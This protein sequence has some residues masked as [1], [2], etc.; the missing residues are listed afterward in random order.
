MRRLLLNYLLPLL[1]PF[2]AYGAWVMLVRWRTRRAGETGG[3]EW[4]DA[5]WTWLFIA[6]LG[7]M[8]IG[9]AVFGHLGRSPPD[10]AYTPAR[11]IDG[12]I[13]PGRMD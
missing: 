2:I 7:L 8:V 9:F 6:G 4:R 10:S 11:V 1:L 3:P 5:P 13:V 12:E